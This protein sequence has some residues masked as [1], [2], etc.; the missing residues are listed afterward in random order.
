MIFAIPS[1]RKEKFNE[2]TR[3]LEL[4]KVF[5]ENLALS[6]NKNDQI[7]IDDLSKSIFKKILKRKEL[8]LNLNEINFFDNKVVMITGGAGS[9]GGNLALLL[10]KTNIKKLLIY[11][12]SELNIYNLD[13]KIKKNLKR[14]KFI[15]GDINDKSNIESILKKYKVTYIFHAAANKH[16]N[17]TENNPYEVIKNNIFGTLNILEASKLYNVHLTIISTDKAAGPKSLLGYTKRFSELLNLYVK[18]EK[19]NIL[20]FGNV[21]ASNGSALPRWISQIN[22]QENIT[23]TSKKAKRYFMTIREACYLV[24][25]TCKLKLINK[26]FILNMG[27]QIKIFDIIKELVRLKKII[28]PEYTPSYQNIGLQKG[29]K[30][31]EKLSLNKKLHKTLI[32]NVYYVEEPI[33]DSK[34][35]ESILD[36]LKKFKVNGYANKAKILLKDFFKK[37][38]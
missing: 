20:R 11:D 5:Y 16:V 1:L 2:I 29:E 38:K 32:K 10:L 15:L 35:V 18:H 17:I 6:K 22:N 26:I 28:N 9:I 33:Y 19:V 37:E 36:N 30:L 3:K 23:I 34:L 8:I 14:A 31:N 4:E 27:N 21:I 13:S 25:S 7:N 24:L 12:N